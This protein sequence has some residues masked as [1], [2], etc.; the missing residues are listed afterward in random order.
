MATDLN[1]AESIRLDEG[2]LRGITYHGKRAPRHRSGGLPR[3]LSVTFTEA[4]ADSHEEPER[5]ELPLRLDLWE[6]SPSGFDWGYG[7]SG[8]A[9]LA[10]AI[11]AHATGDDA[12]ARGRHQDYKWAIIN[13]LPTQDFI[14][15]GDRVLRWVKACPMSPRVRFDWLPAGDRSE[16]IDREI[17]ADAKSEC[18]QADIGY[19]RIDSPDRYDAYAWCL[20][21]HTKI[22]L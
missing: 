22:E 8:P 14:L 12:F 15:H 9:Q 4:S 16:I 11:L 17:L 21:C 2:R 19:R 18:C 7:G 1:H 13:R 10:V 3:V 5:Q 6:H 20:T